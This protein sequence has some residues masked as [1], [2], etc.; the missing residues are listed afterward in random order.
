MSIPM[1]DLLTPVSLQGINAGAGLQTR[2]DRKYLASSEILN[3]LPTWIG[4]RGRILQIGAQRSFEYESVYFDT[5]DLLSYYQAAHGRRRRFKVRTRAYLDSGT[6]F[7]EAKTTGP[8]GRTVKQ[9]IPHP[10][11]SLCALDHQ[12]RAYAAEVIAGVG[13][14]PGLAAQLRPTV[15]TRYRRTTM[16]LAEDAGAISR[17]TVDTELHWTLHAGELPGPALA[18]PDLVIIETKSAGAATTVDRALWGCGIR[19][20]SLSKYCTGLALLRPELPANKWHRVL[21]HTLRTPQP[22]G[23]R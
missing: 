16:A 15:A 17:I 18:R 3:E 9:R 6:A 11:S 12:A 20:V 19:P 21:S 4:R 2:V 10:D 5:P 13:L 14:P 8:R 7:L 22:K 1:T 23:I